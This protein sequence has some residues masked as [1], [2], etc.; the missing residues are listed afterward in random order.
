MNRV[1]RAALPDLDEIVAESGSLEDAFQLFLRKG[2]E[3]SDRPILPLVIRDPLIVDPRDHVAKAVIVL[4][5]K[6]IER[7]PVVRDGQLVGTVARADICWAVV[8][9]S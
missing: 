4:F 2:R 9:E 8:G 3:L 1:L 6:S 5:D 7:L